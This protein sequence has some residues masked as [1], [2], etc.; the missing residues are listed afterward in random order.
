MTVIHS[1]AVCLKTWKVI[2]SS[3]FFVIVLVTRKTLILLAKYESLS[4]A[5]IG[6]SIAICRGAGEGAG[7]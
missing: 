4:C 7:D 6:T 1:L 2:N 3:F 5:G